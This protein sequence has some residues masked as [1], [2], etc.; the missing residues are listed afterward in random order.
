MQ[1]DQKEFVDIIVPRKC[2]ATNKI[3]NAK[4]HASIVVSVPSNE[5]DK[6]HIV[7]LSGF[8]RA[9]GQSDAALNRFFRSKGLLSFE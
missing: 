7:C 8:V 5:A 4:D 3:L 6:E 1:N 9:K 2:Y